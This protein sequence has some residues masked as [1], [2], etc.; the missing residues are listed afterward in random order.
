MA[1]ALAGSHPEQAEW[2][3]FWAFALR[4][5]GKVAE[6]KAVALRGLE[7]HPDEAILRYN[8]ACYLSLLGEL[9]EAKVELRRSIKLDRSCQKLAADDPDLEAVWDSF[10]E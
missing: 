6:A 3:F 2:W 10:G 7:R 4:E 9:D 5:Y 8:L 1:R